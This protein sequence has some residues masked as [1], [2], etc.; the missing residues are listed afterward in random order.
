MILQMRSDWYLPLCM[1]KERLRVDG[2]KAHTAQKPGALLYRVLLSSTNP[3]DIVLDPFFGTLA[4]PGRLPG[5]TA[6]LDR[7]RARC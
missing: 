7:C 5:V 4:Q 1:G 6:P 2:E 3:G